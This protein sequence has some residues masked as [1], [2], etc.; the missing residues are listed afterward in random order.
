MPR[1]T[2]DQIPEFIEALVALGCN[3]QALDSEY[4]VIGDADLPEA[5]IPKLRGPLEAVF[6]RYQDREPLRLEIVAYLHSIGRVFQYS[7]HEM[8]AYSDQ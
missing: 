2:A 1:M 7:P 8:Q 3:V 4:Y 6:A 5:L